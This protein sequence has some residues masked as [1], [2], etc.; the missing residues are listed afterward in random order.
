MRH[1]VLFL[2]VTQFR[3]WIYAQKSRKESS[4]K[5]SSEKGPREK[6][7]EK[8]SQKGCQKGCQKVREEAVQ[9]M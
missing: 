2:H 8:G 3:R 6:S 7:S 1:V 9:K 5:G 4:Q